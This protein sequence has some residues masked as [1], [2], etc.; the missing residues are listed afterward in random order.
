MTWTHQIV[1]TMTTTMTMTQHTRFA[2]R[3]LYV[4]ATV[5][6]FHVTPDATHSHSTNFTSF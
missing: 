1:M 4:L 2:T 3:T 6:N 5:C